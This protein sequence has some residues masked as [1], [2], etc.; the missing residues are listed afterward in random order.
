MV[1]VPGRYAAG[2]ARQALR[3]RPQ[4]VPVQRQRDARRGGRAQARG[5]GARPARS[6][7][8]LRHRDRQRRRSRLRQPRA[9]AARRSRRGLGHRAAGRGEP[10]PRAGRRRLARPRHRRARSLG[11]K[12][13]ARPPSRRSAFSRATRRRGSSRSSRS[14]RRP[15]SR[16]ACSRRPAPCA[17]RSSCISSATDSGPRGSAISTSRHPWPKPRIFVLR[18]RA[19]VARSGSRGLDATDGSRRRTSRSSRSSPAGAEAGARDCSP[20]ARWRTRRC[21]A[22][23]AVLGRDRLESA[24]M[25]GSSAT[26][27]ACSI[28]APTNSPSGGL[29]R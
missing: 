21:S 12:S 24:R 26:A 7:P 2:V 14:R 9:A 1:S 4:R 6:R 22:L 11:A 18:W 3:R 27:T 8:G 16:R 29:I 23:R 19:G 25:T 5:G 28:S 17:S 10:H 15:T 20:A 13:A